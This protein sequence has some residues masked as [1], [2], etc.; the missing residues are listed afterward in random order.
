M[1]NTVAIIQARLASTRLPGKV[2]QDIAG[3]PML[4]W[5]VERT[6]K[7]NL[8]DHVVI[9]TT[10]DSSDDD[11]SLFCKE[12]DYLLE[13]GS[14][15]DVLDRYYQTARRYEAEIIVRV[16]A[17]CP[18]IDPGLVDDAVG[19][20]LGNQNP[21]TPAIPLVTN[22]FDF[23]ANRLPLPWGRTYPIGLDVE[24]FTFNLLE[25]AWEK[26]EE[27]HQRE[28]VAPY[29]YED[30]AVDD[31]KY[32]DSNIP[33]ARTI[34]PKD[35]HVALMH[36]ASDFGHLR[37]TVD[38]PEDLELVRLIADQFP[39]MY[40]GWRDILKLTQQNPEL[41]QINAHIHHKTHLDVDERST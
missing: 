5:V 9:A 35:Y 8:V 22:P 11:L 40:F 24:T 32:Q 10:L 17:D 37:W 12:R 18:F 1:R 13:R 28:H 34:T 33:F 15:F 20:L 27:K 38:T 30:A 16:T 21:Q 41:I 36:H 19:L 2:L 31:L 39:D 25:E 7:S 26:A 23:V 4:D 6:R 14:A 29:F 3:K